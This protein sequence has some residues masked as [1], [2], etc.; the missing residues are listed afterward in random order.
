MLC[1][2]YKS[3]YN[4]GSKRIVT[5]LK[6]EKPKEKS[7]K[8]L[9]KVIE[10]HKGQSI[11]IILFLLYKLNNM[12]H[13]KVRSRNLS[14]APLR[15]IE[16]PFRV[17]YRMGSETPTNKIFKKKIPRGAKVL[18]INSPEACH[19]SGDKI[20][21]KRR[22]EKGRVRTAKWF[23]ISLGDHNDERIQH[24]LNKWDVIIAKY[25]HSSKGKG[26]YRIANY[27]EFLKFKDSIRNLNQSIDNFIFERYYSYTREYRIHV[28]KDG[29]FYASRKVLKND[30][31]DRWHRH[32]DNS[33][34]LNE[35]NPDFN[36]PANWN[37]IVDDCVHALKSLGLDIAAFDVKVAKDGKYIILES[38][39]APALGEFGIQKYTE[40]LNKIIHNG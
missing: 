5:Q 17:I 23:T 18:E 25:K 13:L 26:I 27:D 21:M 6:Y 31:K 38:N 40:V 19:I 36:K 32:A 3:T 29:Y 22:F 20:L 4:A 35:D 10:V 1:L 30:A 15:L 2:E 11:Q 39:S 28:T 16:T 34:F 8:S 12:W 37:T 9:L 14:C 33:V 24:Y 7:Y